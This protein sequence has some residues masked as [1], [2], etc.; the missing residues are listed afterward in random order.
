MTEGSSSHLAI[1]LPSLGGGGAERV[2]INLVRE[3]AR[4]GF[5]VDLVVSSAG[6][7]YTADVPDNVRLIDLH[8]SRVLASLPGLVRYL[9]RERPDALLA[10]MT[11]TNIV[12]LWAR[13]LARVRTRILVSEHDTLSNV[14][15]NAV[16]R[17]TRLLPYLVRRFYPDA[18]VIIAVSSGV[19]DD[20]AATTGLDR[21]CIEVVFNP[22]VTTGLRAAAREAVD[23]PWLAEG[24][25][26][27]V[28][29]MGRL[30]P[31]KNFP[32]LL[33]SFAAARIDRDARLIILG[34]GAEREKLEAL[35]G[36]LGLE[37][38]VS[39]P[40]F[41]ENPFGYLARAS[42]FVLS[43]EYEGLPTALIEAMSCGVP[44]VSTDCP[45][46]PFEILDG[47]RHGRLVP[48]GDVGAM[49]EAVSAGLAGEIEPPSPE[50][51]Q[52]FAVSAIAD[53]YLELTR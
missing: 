24:G 23:H 21:S 13:R 28:I 1:L 44:V 48:V 38:V 39:M 45:A 31:K 2:T 5:R 25:P 36:T 17:R 11:H 40:G 46:G 29:G 32:A 51:W 49:A 50:S 47:G 27:V 22:V 18:D 35:V 20:L 43:S 16:L 14:S 7:V 12:A 30:E 33:R 52:G 26:P 42:L 4:R 9:R 53:Q 8:S 41:V 34:E 37:C 19:A 6:G 10:V 3:I 15:K